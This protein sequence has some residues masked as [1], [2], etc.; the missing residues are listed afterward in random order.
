MS[1]P[2]LNKMYKKLS[3]KP[4]DCKR[5]KY[6]DYNALVDAIIQISPPYNNEKGA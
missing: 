2:T 4:T 1:A 3:K 6:E 5:K